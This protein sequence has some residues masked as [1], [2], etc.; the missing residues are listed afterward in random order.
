MKSNWVTNEAVNL[1][2]MCC[3]LVNGLMSLGLSAT[4]IP[5][6]CTPAVLCFLVLEMS[7]L[8]TEA[9]DEKLQIQIILEKFKT[10]KQV[11]KENILLDQ[12]FQ[13]KAQEG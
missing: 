8:W 5:A 6:K 13:Q 7:D 9:R 1:A 4:D 3:F 10:W 11:F 2:G 12:S